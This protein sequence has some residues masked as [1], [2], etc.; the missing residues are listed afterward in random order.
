MKRNQKFEND[1]ERSRFLAIMC[2]W[3]T[4]VLWLSL[5][6]NLIKIFP[7][8]PTCTP[9]QDAQSIQS[10]LSWLSLQLS[11]ENQQ[12]LYV[13]SGVIEKK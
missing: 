7:N 10:Q 1:Q 6:L 8:T 9:S 5:G 13:L 11:E 4:V 12:C 3:L 2:L